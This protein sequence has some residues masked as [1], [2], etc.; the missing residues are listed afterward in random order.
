L[1]L[2]YAVCAVA[3]VV[4]VSDQYSEGLE[5]KPQLVDSFSLYE[6]CSNCVY[7]YTHVNIA[8]IDVITLAVVMASKRSQDHTVVV[9]CTQEWNRR[10]EWNR[11][12][13][14]LH[15]QHSHARK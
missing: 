15:N 10:Q 11:K 2:P 12:S 6:A 5:L 13:R 4:K 3:L 1:L 14:D 9:I 8:G 7:V